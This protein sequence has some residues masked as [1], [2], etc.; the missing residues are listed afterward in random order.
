[1]LRGQGLLALTETGVVLPICI[2][3]NHFKPEKNNPCNRENNLVSLTGIQNV[4][5]LMRNPTIHH[6]PNTGRQ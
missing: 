5:L 6:I 1:M 4:T 2:K 3:N